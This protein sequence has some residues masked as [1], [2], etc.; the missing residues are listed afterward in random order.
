MIKW[1]N[2]HNIPLPMQIWLATNN[3]EYDP[4]PRVISA[5][6]LLKSTRQIVLGRRY[7]DADRTADFSD[8]IASVMG[9]SIHASVEKALERTN[10]EKVLNELGYKNASSIMDEMH[11]EV[12]T[13]K[14][15]DGYVISGQFDMAYKGIVCDI[16]STS[17]WNYILDDGEDKRKQLCIYRWLNPEIITS[18]RGYNFYVFTDWSAVRARAETT[19]PQSRIAFKE[20]IVD[21][22]EVTERWIRDKLSAIT[23][24][25]GL[26]DDELPRCSD[27]ELWKEETTYAYYLDETKRDRATKVCSTRKEAEDYMLKKGYRGVIVERKGKA[28][29]C[30]YCP[31]TQYC[32]QYTDLVVSGLIQED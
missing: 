6:T 28:K 15:I 26:A 24:C 31:Y 21:E 30:K 7:R 32:N 13:K 14:E 9:S 27:K 12:R 1:T 10:A 4:D 17:T 18:N 16:K 20:R 29:A 19:Y 2:K 22:P 3:Y 8:M 11:V 23:A 5:T 25:S